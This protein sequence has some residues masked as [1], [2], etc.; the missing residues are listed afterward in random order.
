M[1]DF[2]SGAVTIGYVLAALF[3]VRFWRR[4][5]DRLFLAFAIAFGL[6]ALN[7][8]LAQALWAGRPVDWEGRWQVQRG[9]L[10]P[11]PYRPGGPPIW[12]AGSQPAG[13][14]RVGRLFDG[15][16][17]NADAPAQWRQNWT[18]IKRIAAE[19]G[20]DPGKL[21]GAMYVTLAV[22]EDAQLGGDIAE[23]LQNS[24]AVDE[25]S[26]VVGL[27]DAGA[28]ERFHASESTAAR[29][30]SARPAWGDRP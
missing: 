5:A 6:L 28:K 2:L 11:T 24:R 7:Q 8:G 22:D 3:F 12:G 21:T 29:C 1:I 18:E 26:R 20:R 16:L 10:A 23:H 25:P 13:L 14:E 9:T 30:R 27:G 19:A 17:P 15:W 4:T